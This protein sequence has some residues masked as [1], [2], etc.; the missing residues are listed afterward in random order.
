MSAADTTHPHPSR[1]LDPEALAHVAAIVPGWLE[2]VRF[3]RRQSGLQAAIWYDGEVVANVA[4]GDADMEA[5]TPLLPTHRLRIAS[6][7]K[8]FTALAVMRLVERG[9][10][11]LDDTVGERVAALADSPV[12]DR[13][14]RDLLSHS[15]GISR[16]STDSRW[17]RLGTPFPD[18]RQLLELCRSHAVVTEPGVHLQYSNIGYGILGLVIE[19]ATDA[20]FA[21]AVNEL[22]LEPVGIDEIGPDL[23]ADA[24]GPE[25]AD[26]FALGHTAMLHG[27]RRPVEQIPTGALAAATG[28]WATAS[29][30]ASFAGEV[31]T[32][33][34]LLQPRSLREMRRRVWTVRD[35][36]HYGLGLQEGRFHGFAAIG[37]SGG[38][39]TGLT[40]TWAVPRER[41][42]VS[43]LG[44][45]VDAPSSELAVGILG[46][47][48][49][50]A[51]RPAPEA[52]SW[53][54][55]AALGGASD[56][57]ERPAVLAEQDP[58]RIHDRQLDGADVAAL[59]EGTYDSLWGRSRIA[60]IGDR[61]FCLDGAATDPAS[62]ALE[63]ALDGVQEDPI[64]PGARCI[65]LMT[66]GDAGYGTWA[67][68]LLARVAD[69]SG[70]LRC[71]GVI[72][73]GQ[74][75]T[76][77]DEFVM[78]DR[79]VRPRGGAL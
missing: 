40:R 49:L 70:S 22:V 34:A 45:A 31:L 6:H 42:A 3:S 77:S 46:L 26:G 62:T 17:W 29:A 73:T 36:G 24:A 75:L 14:L 67:E 50:A 76:P 38:F 47:V 44:T 10:L 65:R 56:G 37:H 72:D 7:S 53:E 61:L 51:G 27:P 12:A 4:V 33:D 21:E 55:A 71:T 15:A 74:V 11:R 5:P 43:V 79:V 59:V 58:V 39:P 20:P 66:W 18:R 32:H 1:S 57:R 30:I 16:D 48:A 78:P 2:D 19:E 28:F 54:G 60:R 35:G 68:P 23:P 8:M 52:D 69:E 64:T 25:Q 9:R 63:L 13:T 41:L